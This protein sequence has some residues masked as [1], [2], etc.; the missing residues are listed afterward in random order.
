MECGCIIGKIVWGRG[1]SL[2][3]V[4][5]GQLIHGLIACLDAQFKCCEKC[6]YG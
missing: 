6:L 2:T 5:I 4:P 3:C 1:S